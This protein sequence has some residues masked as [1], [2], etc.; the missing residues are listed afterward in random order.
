MLGWLRRKL[1][2]HPRAFLHGLLTYPRFLGRIKPDLMHGRE[3]EILARLFALNRRWEPARL[4]VPLGKRLLVL[5]PHADD[6]TIGPGGLLLAHR[7][8]CEIHIVNLFNGE[9]GGRLPAPS[10]GTAA[11]EKAQLIA[12]RR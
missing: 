2:W 3:E 12:A 7:G 6:E 1:P 8:K 9:G 5:A 10:A 4:K 11:D